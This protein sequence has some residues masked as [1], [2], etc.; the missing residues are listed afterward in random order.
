MW[1]MNKITEVVA[2]Q[3]AIDFT[4]KSTPV[5]LKMHRR[6]DLLVQAVLTFT[7]KGGYLSKALGRRKGNLNI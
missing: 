2:G 6:G 1:Q 3:S 4:L 7:T 5:T